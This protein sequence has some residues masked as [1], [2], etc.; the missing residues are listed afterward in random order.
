MVMKLLFWCISATMTLAKAAQG[1]YLSLD[2]IKLRL[3]E[4]CSIG[5]SFTDLEP[6][7]TL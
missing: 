7:Y 6:K 3:L 1:T 5:N 4:Q 2:K